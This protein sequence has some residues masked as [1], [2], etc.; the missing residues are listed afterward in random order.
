MGVLPNPSSQASEE[1]QYSRWLL[2]WTYRLISGSTGGY[3]RGNQEDLDCPVARN[4]IRTKGPI[5]HRKKVILL[6]ET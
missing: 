4:K 1:V 5:L 3:K 6:G 2:I